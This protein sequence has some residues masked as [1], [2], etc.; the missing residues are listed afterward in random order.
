MRSILLLFSLFFLVEA[1]AEAQSRTFPY[2]AEIIT[3]VAEIRSGPGT[4]YYSTQRLKHGTQVTVM[5]HDPGGWCMIVPPTNSFSWIPKQFVKSS[6]NRQGEVIA[7]NTIV[8]VGS[9]LNDLRDVEQRRLSRGDR[10]QIL[11][12]KEIPTN[13]GKV[14]Y[15]QISPPRGE[16]RWV[17]GTA[18]V[19][20]DLNQRNA[21]DENPYQIPSSVRKKTITQVGHEEVEAKS[22]TGSSIDLENPF[23]RTAAQ[24]PNSASST[25]PASSASLDPTNDV[26]DGPLSSEVGKSSSTNNSPSKSHVAPTATAGEKKRPKAI[27]QAQAERSPFPVEGTQEVQPP[28]QFPSNQNAAPPEF[29]TPREV[30]R[31]ITNAP[32]ANNR[33]PQ[34]YGTPNQ[35]QQLDDEF[36]RILESPMD[37]WN[38]TEL[39]RGYRE[40]QN[41]PEGTAPSLR[42]K[43]AVRFEALRRSKYKKSRY[44]QFMSI[45][46]GTEQ[47]DLELV[48]R[49]EQLGS[50]SMTSTIPRIKGEVYKS[51]YGETVP[52]TQSF[53]TETN[54][55]PEIMSE[56]E[57]PAVPAEQNSPQAFPDELKLPPLNTSQNGNPA[58]NGKYSGAGIVRRIV[59]QDQSIPS[60]VLVTQDGRVLA[61]L[62]SDGKVDLDKF[63]EKP[64]GTLGPREFNKEL[65]YDLIHVTGLEGVRL[66][67]SIA[68]GPSSDTVPETSPSQPSAKSKAP[69]S[70]AQTP[71]P[72]PQLQPHESERIEQPTIL[73]PTLQSPGNS[74]S[75]IQ[76]N[77]FSPGAP[78]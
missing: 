64:V 3:Q 16:Y 51:P 19:P 22:S 31:P 10:V 69:S 25:K 60:H 55:L 68:K 42:R 14:G 57:L 59:N 23:A 18:L 2:E 8:R 39:E 37:H 48:S 27:Q 12:E 75:G 49:L 1:T 30:Q 17:L 56:Q 72:F 44:D 26:A 20:I 40:L 45:M 65:N 74:S 6:E 78:K 34:Q 58:P 46:Q 32:P 50:Q 61:Y 36:A 47:R 29:T 52:S 62:K 13:S 54:N 53:P 21:Q 67:K 15:Y 5:R 28:S 24:T 7:D 73:N 66:G 43:L 4:R 35:L 33:T 38:F 63:L 77:P 11:G 76:Y 71:A 41:S 9:R 70:S